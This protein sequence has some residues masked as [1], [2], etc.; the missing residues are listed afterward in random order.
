MS[1]ESSFFKPGETTFRKFIYVGAAASA[2]TLGAGGT[3]AAID[4]LA[5]LVSK[6]PWTDA[7]AQ[8]A[9]TDTVKAL[10]PDGV[11]IAVGL[12]AL[13]GAGYLFAVPFILRRRDDEIEAN[14]QAKG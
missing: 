7:G 8:I 1:K 13:M 2:L 5:G 10:V 14:Q 6:A 9:K 11:E 12:G 4:G 3:Y